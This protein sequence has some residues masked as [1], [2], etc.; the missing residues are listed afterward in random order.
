MPYIAV[1]SKPCGIRAARKLRVVRRQERWADKKYKK[2]HNISSIKANVLGGATMAKGIVLEKVGV[3]AKQPNSAIRKCVRVQ[4]IKNGKKITAFVPRDGCLNYVDEND[5]VLI[6]GFGRSG[7]AVGDIP[8]VRFKVV[9]VSK[10]SLLAL[11]RQK[12]EKPHS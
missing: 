5:E 11:F 4:L 3:E 1:A 12:K 8:G 2:G 6:A 9:C 10:T 7:H